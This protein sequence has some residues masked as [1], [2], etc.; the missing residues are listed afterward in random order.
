MNKGLALALSAALAVLA[1]AGLRRSWTAREREA[2]RNSVQIA[3]AARDLTAGTAVSLQDLTLQSRPEP[4]A[5]PGL[6]RGGDAR[7][8][9]GRTLLNERRAGEAIAWADLAEAS[10]SLS[11]A[12]PPGQR[13]FTIRVDETT[14]VGGHLH[15]NARVDVLGVF[16][17]PSSDDPEGPARVVCRTVASNVTILAAGERSGGDAPGEGYA[18]VTLAVSPE[19]AQ[20]LAL[21][22]REGELTLVLRNPADLE[23]APPGEADLASVLDPAGVE[24]RGERR[25][26]RVRIIRGGGDDPR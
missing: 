21:A 4:Y 22:S 5:D 17:L 8:I 3:A 7:S 10:R 13:A 23:A 24:A 2:E 18:T 19:E 12:V 6:V 11:E 16:D 15:P 14:G 20:A 1:V 25:E 26:E 9:L